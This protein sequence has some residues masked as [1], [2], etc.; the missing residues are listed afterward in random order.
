MGL[1]KYTGF[2]LLSTCHS[3][4]LKSFIARNVDIITCREIYYRIKPHFDNYIEV[5]KIYNCQLSHCQLYF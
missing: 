5:S 3:F 2:Q 1:T 4:L